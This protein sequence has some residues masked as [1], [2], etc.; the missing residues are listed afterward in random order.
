MTD[1]ESSYGPVNYMYK[2]ST[3]KYRTDLALLMHSTVSAYR[4]DRPYLPCYYNEHLQ[5][6]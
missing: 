1:V 2:T 5:P 6:T 3:P 4:Q